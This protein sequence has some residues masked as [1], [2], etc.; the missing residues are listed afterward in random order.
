MNFLI[1]QLDKE[2]LC[3]LLGEACLRNQLQCKN[4]RCISKTL[5][6]NGINDCEDSSD[7]IGNCSCNYK[8]F[9]I[10]YICG[11]NFISANIIK[12][13]KMLLLNTRFLYMGTMGTEKY[14]RLQH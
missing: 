5:V 11:I 6:C 1:Q 2:S 4:G 10:P 14:L 7:E 13:K 12:V 9:I 3:W 8:H